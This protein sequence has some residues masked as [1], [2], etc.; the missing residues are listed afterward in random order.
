MAR[1]TTLNG[2]VTPSLLDARKQV[3]HIYS[4]VKVYCDSLQQGSLPSENIKDNATIR[5]DKIIY[6]Q[7]QRQFVV[8]SHNR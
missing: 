2:N 7:T 1:N 5:Q 8:Y 6:F 3:N 4:N